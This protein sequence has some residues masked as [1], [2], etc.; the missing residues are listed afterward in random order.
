MK[1]FHNEFKEKNVLHKSLFSTETFLE[2]GQGVLGIKKKNP[3]EKEKLHRDVSSLEAVML[4][5]LLVQNSP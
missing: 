2:E 4:V 3:D 5:L 1:H